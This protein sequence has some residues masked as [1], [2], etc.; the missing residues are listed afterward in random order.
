[1]DVLTTMND[2]NPK[3]RSALKLQAVVLL[4]CLLGGP[5]HMAA[6]S[7]L[8]AKDDC[9]AA[10]ICKMHKHTQPDRKSESACDHEKKNPGTNCTM[11]CGE[12]SKES[13]VVSSGFPESILVAEIAILDPRESRAELTSISHAFKN[14][15]LTPPD[16]PPR[17]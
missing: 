3:R 16:L 13:A 11:K 7:L 2:V 17:S 14:Q 8:P 10:G 1:M 9:C 5:L 6:A 4:M 15:V 12:A